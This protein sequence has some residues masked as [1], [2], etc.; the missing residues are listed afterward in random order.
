MQLTEEQMENFESAAFE[1]WQKVPQQGYVRWT[2]S[3]D[4]TLSED[5]ILSAGFDERRFY[6]ID[7][8]TGK[9]Y[10]CCAVELER[11]TDYVKYSIPIL[12]E[13]Q[14]AE[15]TENS[16]GDWDYYSAYIH[17]K[18]DAEH[19]DGVITGVYQEIDADSTLFPDK[20]TIELL[21]GDS[22]LPFIFARDIV[23]NED[24]SVAPFEEW[25]STSHTPRYFVLEGSLGVT[26]KEVAE[27]AEYCGLFVIRDTQ[28]NSYTTNPVYIQY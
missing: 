24:G 22:I 18:V 10:A 12:L 1:A 13:R 25:E 11:D 2:S 21:E 26:M 16:I 23:F 20:D 14:V 5:G 27:G 19:P 15:A 8:S 4:V 28:G 7:E 17:V 9:E 3:S 6:L